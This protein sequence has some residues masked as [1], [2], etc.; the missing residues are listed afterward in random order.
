MAQQTINIGTIADD[1]TGDP[2]RTAF[3]K[4]NSN[5]TELYTDKADAATVTTAL[6]AKAPLASPALT[7]TPT[8]PTA[9]P[10]T[11]TTQLATT[12]YVDAAVT[13]GGGANALDDLTDVDTTGVADGDVLTY[14]S[15]ASAWV[16]AASAGGGSGL[17]YSRFDIDKPPSSPSALDDEFTSGTSLDAKWTAVNLS[18]TGVSTSHNSNAPDAYEVLMESTASVGFS[19]IVQ[20][21]PAGDFTL[22]MKGT[23]NGPVGNLGLVLTSS[24]TYGAGTQDVVL[25]YTSGGYVRGAYRYNNWNGF[26]ANLSTDRSWP[27]FG[28]IFLRWRRSGTTYYA[29]WSVTGRSWREEAI[30]PGATPTHFGVL[31]GSLANPDM[32]Y[33]IE[34]VRYSTSATAQFGGTI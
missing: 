34:W 17:G 5:F 6:A 12:A 8:A 25:V 26:A 11:N 4:A 21:I 24:A 19:G 18:R 3:D 13:A 23:M 22:V 29:G 14:D 28:P 1:G 9:A 10:G 27:A 7:G 15:G 30:T 33:A 2:L 32:A 16:P 20:A 31:F